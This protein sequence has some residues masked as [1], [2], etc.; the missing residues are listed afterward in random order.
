MGICNQRDEAAKPQRNGTRPIVTGLHLTGWQSFHWKPAS[1]SLSTLRHRTA[2]SAALPAV[3]A[4]PKKGT[5]FPWEGPR[6]RNPPSFVHLPRLDQ[7]PAPTNRTLH[8]S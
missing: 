5:F 2:K 6:Y 3:S 8:A 7:P 1:Q 4:G